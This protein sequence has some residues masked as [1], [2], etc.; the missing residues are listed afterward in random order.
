MKKIIRIV[1]KNILIMSTIVFCLILIFHNQIKYTE[2]N[3]KTESIVKKQTKYL[4][5]EQVKK[6]AEKPAI[7]DIDSV[8]SITDSAVY[9]SQLMPK[10]NAQYEESFHTTGFVAVPS[11]RINLPIFAGVAN[12]NLLY[13]AGTVKANQRMGEGN[14]ALASHR[15]SNPYLLFTPLERIKLGDL[16]YTSDQSRIYEY[17]VEDIFRV[18]PN[19]GD[20]LD[21]V[22]G[23]KLITL[24][25]C[26][27]MNAVKRIVVRGKFTES[28]DF[29]HAPS[30]AKNAFDYMT[31]TL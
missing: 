31:K 5:P 29:K 19:R 8:E 30:Y 26:S 15:T 6:N 7:Y 1:L 24:V 10:N 18:Y 9:Q 27:D 16:I 20:L 14:Y 22:E 17:Q 21:D 11:V 13:G 12:A 25:T 23:K 3:H 28:W 4:T 2:M